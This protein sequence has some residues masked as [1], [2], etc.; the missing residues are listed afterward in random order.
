M[1]VYLFT[2]LLTYYIALRLCNKTILCLLIPSSITTSMLYWDIHT[3][4]YLYMYHVFNWVTLYDLTVDTANA[5]YGDIE[6][7][8]NEY[9]IPCTVSKTP[10]SYHVKFI[11]QCAGRHT[12]DIRFNGRPIQRLLLHN[13]LVLHHFDCMYVYIYIL[14]LYPYYITFYYLVTL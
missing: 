10:A 3:Y 7:S 11:K 2:L 4:I 8:I 5:G 13:H 1:C 14:I 9:T 12:I 6:I